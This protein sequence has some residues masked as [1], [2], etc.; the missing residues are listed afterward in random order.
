[1]FPNLNITFSAD[2]HSPTNTRFIN[3]LYPG[4]EETEC[5]AATGCLFTGAIIGCLVS[6]PYLACIG[7]MAGS[8]LGARFQD[9]LRHPHL[10]NLGGIAIHDRNITLLLPSQQNIRR[11]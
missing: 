1:M 4:Y 11:E 2:M 8:I 10:I 9:E 3:V 7:L 6:E 5:V